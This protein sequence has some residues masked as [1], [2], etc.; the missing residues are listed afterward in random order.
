[1]IT[2]HYALAIAEQLHEIRTLL[3]LRYSFILFI[4]SKLIINCNN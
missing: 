2:R 1:M 4:K 3:L